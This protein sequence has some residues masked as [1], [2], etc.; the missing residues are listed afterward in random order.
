MA[1]P[2]VLAAVGGAKEVAY[3][4]LSCATLIAVA[5]ASGSLSRAIFWSFAGPVV[6]M[7]AGLALFKFPLAAAGGLIVGVASLTVLLVMISEGTTRMVSQW[8][9][10]YNANLALIGELEEARDRAVAERNAADVA[11]E[12]ARQANRAKSNFLATMSH[13]IRTPMNGVL[14]MAQLLKREGGDP[15]QADRLETLIES[16]EHLLS[17][18]NDILDVSKVD[19]GQLD[20][21]PQVENLPRFLE[22]LVGFWGARADEKG[23]ALRLEADDDLPTFVWMDPVR[24]RQ[25]LFNLVGN[26]L[27]FTDTGSVTVRVSARP[28]G[29]SA[30]MVHFAVVDTGMGIPGEH[31]PV[32]FER[33]SQVDDSQERKFGGTGLGLAIAKRLT[34][35]MGGRIW[36]ESEV[37][38]G[39]SFQIEASFPLAQSPVAYEGEA[40]EEPMPTLE[41]DVLIVDDNPVNLMV[42][43]QIL[44]TFGHRVA[45]ASSGPAALEL[46]AARPFDLILMDIQMPDM[47]GTQTLARLRAADG[48]NQ[49]APVIA[50]TADVTS[51]GRPHYLNLGFNEHATKPIQIPELMASIERTMTVGRMQP[52]MDALAG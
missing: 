16:G 14:G 5:G 2:I 47:T 26:A 11:R 18:L 3:V 7:L 34:E 1:G 44:L 49:L 52:L 9:G 46:A 50:L 41:L 31:L 13:E 38:C 21:T 37:G 22:R 23:L 17:I 36:V 19:A 24:M 15:A 30:A 10:A 20:I 39:S 43:Q 12:E 6:V 42:L 25:V 51:G 35:L 28:D 32:L 4:G 40:T 48:P 33:F 27:K 29:E 8:Q 45:T